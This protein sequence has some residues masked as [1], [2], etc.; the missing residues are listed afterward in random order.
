[1]K[2]LFMLLVVVCLL[3]LPAASQ[4]QPVAIPRVQFFDSSGAP[5]S[6]GK[7]YTFGAGT[8]DDAPTY[9]D[10]AG[11]LNANP[12]IL[13][14]SGS[15]V[16]YFGPQSYK[17]RLD[18][19]ADVTVFTQDNIPGAGQS[20]VSQAFSAITADTNA[21]AGTFA[22]SGNVWDFAAATSLKVVAGAGAAPTASGLLAY[23]TTANKFVFGQ[24]G[25][26][27]SFGLADATGACSANQWVST[28]ATPTALATCSQPAITNLPTFSSATLAGRL[29]D[30][31]GSG[32]GFV[33]A[34]SPTLTTPTINTATLSAGTVSGAAPATPVANRI[35]T[36]SIVKGWVETSGAGAWTIDADVNVASITD[37]GTGDFTV[38]WATPFSSANYAVVGTVISNGATVGYAVVED[39]TT[40]KTA[41]AVRLNVI[42]QSGAVTSIADPPV[43]VSIIAIGIN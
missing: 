41:S 13:D 9:S 28:R 4:I 23:D 20:V 29:T 15:A 5:L 22:L 3:A 31:T 34:T 42:S 25:T 32:G 2:R 37:N 36:D 24:N 26:T 40:A 30:E 17:I 11:T 12:V 14:A 7:V 43:G 33:R 27:V 39:T 1:M 21:N 10:S 8:T 38:N 16:I 18:D 6:G 35:Y 19:S